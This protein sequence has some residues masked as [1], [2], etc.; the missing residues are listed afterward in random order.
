MKDAQSGRWPNVLLLKTR[1]LNDGGY[2]HDAL[3]LLHGKTERDF[4]R[5]EE[6]LEFVYRMGRI[7]DDLGRDAEAVT[8][9]QQAIRIGANRTEYFAARAALQAG[10]LYESKGDK[11]TAISYYRQ[12]L[13][14]GDHEYKNSLDQRAKSG[15]ARCKGE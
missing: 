14:M 5:E 11:A 6:K 12:C 13:D 15:I 3:A 1:L 4:T 7:Y 8:F 9:Y 10:Q 2:H